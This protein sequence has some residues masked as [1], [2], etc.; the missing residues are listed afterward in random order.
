MDAHRIDLLANEEIIFESGSAVLTNQRLL[1]NSED[2]AGDE[3]S[4]EAFL[5]DIVSFQKVTGGQE[6]R[7]KPGAQV[8]AVGAVLLAAE[9]VLP[10]LP[11]RLGAVVFLL[12]GVAVVIGV[13]LL[14]SSA[15]RVRPRTTVLFLVR[16]TRE[17]A[18]VFPGRDNPEADELTRLFARARRR[19]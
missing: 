7:A 18:V 4:D 14:L 6:S 16:G 1:V 5:R 8:L 17:M 12:G 19:L 13:Y 3:T 10:A 15:F 2:A 11:E 9:A